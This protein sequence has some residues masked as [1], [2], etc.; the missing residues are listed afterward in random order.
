[1]NVIK[2]SFEANAGFILLLS[3]VVA[4][5]FPFYAAYNS[6][7]LFLL[8]LSVTVFIIKG[9]RYLIKD[10]LFLAAFLYFMFL[11]MNTRV[12]DE[13]SGRIIFNQIVLLF[14]VHTAKLLTMRRSGL[15]LS[16]CLVFLFTV[17]GY[18]FNLN[19]IDQKPQV[20]LQI[21]TLAFLIVLV[22]DLKNDKVYYHVMLAALI[23]SKVRSVLVGYFP[24]W[25]YVTSISKYI[26]SFGL[27]SLISLSFS[28]IIFLYFVLNI[29][30]LWNRFGSI[31]DSFSWRVIHWNYL[32]Q[33]F[34]AMDWVFGKG[35]GYSWRVTTVFDAYYSTGDAYIASHSNYVKILTETGLVGLFLFLCL[36]LF[37][38]CTS[39]I[40]IKMLVVLYMLYG[41][42]DEGV[43]LYSFPWFVFLV[44]GGRSDDINNYSQ[45]R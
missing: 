13:Y 15:I 6:L 34:E 21:I 35:M 4:S 3:A 16:I 45:Q 18:F 24:V 41:F 31:L 1:M 9:G 42:Y 14:S 11:L 17:Y 37:I 26:R 10:K 25:L 22:A 30:D 33:S 36:M 8:A 28:T 43:W 2:G 7:K 32:F 27:Y 23:I 39:D 12:L 40:R 19:P 38:Y 29:E 44:F 5:S 20:H